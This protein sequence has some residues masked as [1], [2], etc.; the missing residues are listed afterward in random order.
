MAG[1]DTMIT[2]RLLAFGLTVFLLGSALILQSLE[3]L[4]RSIN[5][6]L[7]GISTGLTLIIRI[8]IITAV[9]VFV[10][11]EHRKK[12]RNSSQS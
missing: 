1:I 11:I 5:P 9:L 10:I 4:Y 2:K 8:V 7:A 12:R 6:E 3:G